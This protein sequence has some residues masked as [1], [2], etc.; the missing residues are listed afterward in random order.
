MKPRQ[1]Y[2]SH[3]LKKTALSRSMTKLTRFFNF[4]K[5]SDIFLSKVNRSFRF[6]TVFAEKVV[7]ES[8]TKLT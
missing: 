2:L 1:L 8:Q 3:A 6:P 4:I 7:A 5:S